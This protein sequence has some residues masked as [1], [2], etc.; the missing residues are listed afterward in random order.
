MWECWCVCSNWN[1]RRVTCR[2][3]WQDV[4]YE[5]MGGVSEAG[6]KSKGLVGAVDADTRFGVFSDT[7]FEEVGFALEAD[8]AMPAN[9]RTLVFRRQA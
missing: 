5:E 1:K 4:K 2:K 7:F 3:G 8:H 6:A 9:N